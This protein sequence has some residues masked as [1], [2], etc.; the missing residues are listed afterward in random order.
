MTK[1]AQWKLKE[2][3]QVGGDIFEG[4][5]GIPLQLLYFAPKVS[6]EESKD[7]TIWFLGGFQGPNKND[8]HLVNLTQRAM[9][10]GTFD[11][12]VKIYI[13]PVVNPAY[14]GKSSKSSNATCL[15][16]GALFTGGD[17]PASAPIEA[18]SL[19]RWAK[20]IQPKVVVTFSNGLTPYIRYLN[21]PQDI[22]TRLTELTERACYSVGTEPEDKL[23]DGTV[24]P[25]EKSDAS[26][27]AWCVAQ[28]YSW[29][30]IRVDS[31]KKTFNDVKDSDWKPSFGPAIKWLVE[32]FRFNPP[33]VEPNYELPE[34]IP[35]LE[36]PPEFANL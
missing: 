1:N 28:D 17:L 5:S 13:T 22:V 33:T 12:S 9:D 11:P 3:I 21:I 16:F 27:G 6:S 14:T 2:F 31:T 26:F 7:S 18:K 34:V 36:M 10:K 15:D 35:A 20:T 19:Q 4:G 24:I 23:E 32:G 29:I 25:R 8:A 30:D